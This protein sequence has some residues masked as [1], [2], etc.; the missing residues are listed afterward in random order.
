MLPHKYPE[1]GVCS[2]IIDQGPEPSHAQYFEP[3]TP[4]ITFSQRVVPFAQRLYK[5]QTVK[6]YRRWSGSGP[7]SIIPLH[8]PCSGYL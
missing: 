3:L 8:T 6:I 2:G 1:Q 7:W 5:G 4:S